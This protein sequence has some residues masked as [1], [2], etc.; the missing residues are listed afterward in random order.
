MTKDALDFAGNTLDSP[1]PLLAT[2]VETPPALATLVAV[3]LL[4]TEDVSVMTIEFDAVILDF[5]C[6][7]FVYKDN[8]GEGVVKF[9]VLVLTPD[10][11]NWKNSMAASRPCGSNICKRVDISISRQ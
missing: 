4:V 6:M 7:E 5:A 9:V 11:R 1:S 3:K 2:V 8:E 10:R